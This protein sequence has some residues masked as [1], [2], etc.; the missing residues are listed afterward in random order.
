MAI[1]CAAGMRQHADVADAN[2]LAMRTQA[3]IQTLIFV[4]AAAVCRFRRTLVAPQLRTWLLASSFGALELIADADSVLGS[5]EDA[6]HSLGACLRVVAAVSPG[7]DLHCILAAQ[8]L[9]ALQQAS[10]AAPAIEADDGG[11]GGVAGTLAAVRV[12]CIAAQLTR[13]GH[14]SG[15]LAARLAE[16]NRVMYT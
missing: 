15:G 5:W 3:S 2:L 16:L 7:S 9:S 4:D 6:A 11:S 10:G 8:R 12:E 14:V 1:G 13:Y